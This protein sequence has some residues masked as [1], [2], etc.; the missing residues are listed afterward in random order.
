MMQYSS[1]PLSTS[2]RTW[3]SSYTQPVLARPRNYLTFTPNHFRI[4]SLRAIHFFPQPFS[5]SPTLSSAD[6]FSRPIQ[7]G[8]PTRADSFRPQQGRRLQPEPTKVHWRGAVRWGHEY[9]LSP[10]IKSVFCACVIF[11]TLRYYAY[12]P[13]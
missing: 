1:S 2:P 5:V 4:Q 13:S 12:I 9:I 3:R 11:P 8:P 7:F 6:I 10:D